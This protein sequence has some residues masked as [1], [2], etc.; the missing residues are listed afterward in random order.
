MDRFHRTGTG[1]GVGLAGIRE[2]IKEL[3]GDFTISSTDRGTTLRSEVPLSEEEHPSGKAAITE[4]REVPASK[5]R[6][7]NFVI[8]ANRAV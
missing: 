8:N 5:P 4:I 6:R 3:G 2:R 7:D 1:S